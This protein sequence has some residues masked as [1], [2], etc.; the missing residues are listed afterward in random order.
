MYT[1]GMDGN[2][3]SIEM[4]SH[5]GTFMGWLAHE[6]FSYDFNGIRVFFGDKEYAQSEADRI[7]AEGFYRT[8]VVLAP[9]WT[10]EQP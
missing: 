4:W 2:A 1:R 9:F 8:K 3:Y 10:T 6:E 5:E 7:A